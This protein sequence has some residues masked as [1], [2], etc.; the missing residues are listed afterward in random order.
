MQLQGVATVEAITGMSKSAI[1]NAMKKFGHSE[2]RP[3]DDAVAP[4]PAKRPCAE[5]VTSSHLRMP[6]EHVPQTLSNVSSSA[7]D[8][9]ACAHGFGCVCSMQTSPVTS[10]AST[11]NTWGDMQLLD[12]G[13]PVIDE[14]ARAKCFT[15]EG[16]LERIHCGRGKRQGE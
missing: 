1:C 6:R 11:K 2:P 12:D 15:K 8:A 3:L 5:K 9:N 13:K 10:A 7:V 16:W 4:S 14:L